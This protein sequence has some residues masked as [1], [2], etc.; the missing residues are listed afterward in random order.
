M[1]PTSY[2]KATERGAPELGTAQ[3]GACLTMTLRSLV[4]V[5]RAYIV[6]ADMPMSILGLLI[7][8]FKAGK[9]FIC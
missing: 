3:A 7:P 2:P 1:T 5:V 9:A 6:I 8:I 4:G